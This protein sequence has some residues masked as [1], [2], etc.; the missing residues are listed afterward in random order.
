MPSEATAGTVPVCDGTLTEQMDGSIT[1]SVAGEYVDIGIFGV[2]DI[3]QLTPEELGLMFG[4]GWGALM[5]VFATNW[6]M[7]KLISF[8]KTS[9]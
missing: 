8:V 3:S 4:S 1:C 5:L 2:F 9:L 7:G 6:G